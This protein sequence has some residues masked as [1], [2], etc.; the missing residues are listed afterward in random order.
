MDGFKKAITR[1]VSNLVTYFLM[2]LLVTLPLTA[3]IFG[4]LSRKTTVIEE[5]GSQKWIA[6]ILS[7]LIVASL[8]S[9]ALRGIFSKLE[10]RRLKAVFFFYCIFVSSWSTAVLIVEA[11]KEKPNFGELMQHVILLLFLSAF[12]P[13]LVTLVFIASERLLGKGKKNGQSIRN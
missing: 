6:L 7:I 13:G 4:L 2:A 3:A 12:I 8:G 5:M 1:P 10:K 9:F 11:L